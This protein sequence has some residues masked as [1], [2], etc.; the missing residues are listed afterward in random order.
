MFSFE[1]WNAHLLE[2]SLVVRTFT[3]LFLSTNSFLFPV[4]LRSL[5]FHICSEFVCF[6]K[7]TSNQN[8][9]E[10][11][12]IRQSY[13]PKLDNGLILVFLIKMKPATMKT[14]EGETLSLQPYITQIH[15]I[16]TENS[17]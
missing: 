16:E 1:M 13:R 12:Y 2:Q 7:I 5:L 3:H 15:S 17:I 4:S 10:H 8:R 6:S 9:T 14:W 11:F